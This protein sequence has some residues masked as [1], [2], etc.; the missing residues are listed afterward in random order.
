[1]VVFRCY[2]DDYLRF[3]RLTIV[4]DGQRFERATFYDVNERA[5]DNF[6]FEIV[7]R[8]LP[9]YDQLSRGGT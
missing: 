7:C 8:R 5:G 1:V 6:D 3:K 2:S 4:A 9:A